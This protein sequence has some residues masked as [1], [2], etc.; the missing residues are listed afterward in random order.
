MISLIE[1][2]D[3]ECLAVELEDSGG[4]FVILNAYI[5]RGEGDALEA[6]HEGG[7]QMVRIRMDSLTTNGDIGDLPA[8]IYG[9]SLS[10]ETAVLDNIIPLPSAYPSKFVLTL[11]LAPD[12]REVMMTGREIAI[13]SEGE[14]DFVENVDLTN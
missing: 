7:Y 4:G 10:T 14:F 6:P 9:G 13:T 2:H 1:L 11:T 3:S 5:H 12:A 8:D